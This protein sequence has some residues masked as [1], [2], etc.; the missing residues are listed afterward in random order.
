MP[1]EYWFEEG[2]WISEW[3]NRAHD[4]TLSMVRARVPPGGTTRRHRLNG[5]TERYAVLGGQG[6]IE[7]GDAPPR[8]VGPGDM[9]LISAGA[10]QRISN[11]GAEDLVFF[12]ICTPR[13]TRGA[14]EDLEPGRQEMLRKT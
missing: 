9:V 14:Y 6:R 1:D 10:A 3:W 5:I 8:D 7:V 4:P 11:G 12:A 13:F 2:C